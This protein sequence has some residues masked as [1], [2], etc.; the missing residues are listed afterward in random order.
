MY[1][2]HPGC[3]KRRRNRLR[4]RFADSRVHGYALHRTLAGHAL[5]VYVLACPRGRVDANQG[6]PS[7]V[8]LRGRHGGEIQ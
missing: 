5:E 4:K 7:R 1:S 3:E 8:R 6:R 2:R